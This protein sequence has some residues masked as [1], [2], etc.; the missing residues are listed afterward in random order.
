MTRL[1]TL[2]KGGHASVVAT[3]GDQVTLR[4]SVS[5][6]PG[7]SLAATLEGHSLLVKVRGCRKDPA[8]PTDLPFTIEGRFVS[9]TK[10]QRLAVLGETPPDQRQ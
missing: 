7:S 1:L 6:P 5:S 10:A 3:D 9:L 4:A 2:T 8:N